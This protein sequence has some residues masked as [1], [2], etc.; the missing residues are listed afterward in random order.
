MDAIRLNHD[1]NGLTFEFAVL[2]PIN[3]GKLRYRF[4]LRGMEENW[5]EVDSAHRMAR[6]TD[7]PPGDYVF[8]AQASSDG[9]TWDQ[10]G[11]NVR[12]TI[13]PPWWRT[14]WAEGLGAFL[15]IALLLGAHK[16]RVAVLH[17]RQAHLAALVD[18]RTAEL[19]NARDQAETANRAKS[20]FLANMSHELRTPLNAIL[21]FSNLL[22]ESGVSADQ[23]EKVE[24]I[25]RSGEH[26]LTLID[27][28]LD[29]AKIEAGK[30]TLS[31]APCDLIALVNDVVDMMRVRAS[32]EEPGTGLPAAAGLSA[33]CTDGYLQ[34]AADSDQP[35]EQCHQVHGRRN[36]HFAVERRG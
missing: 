14:W 26:L 7:V 11:V 3:P 15:V 18:Q 29:V 23:R 33:A 27:D 17:R 4:R 32:D 19:A 31:I 9:R 25:N 24:I 16:L 10:G 30:Q 5:T 36:C 2:N 6:Y 8:R 34:A 1:Q 13:V 21:G 35:A 12:L 20:A 28:V 22:R